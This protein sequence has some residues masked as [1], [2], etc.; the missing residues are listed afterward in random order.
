MKDKFETSH[1]FQAFHKMIQNQFHAYV[2][3]FKTDNAYDFLISILG[4]SFE[5]NGIV[6]QSSWEDTP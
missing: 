3:V 2:Q 5:S 4:P 1:I 6:H